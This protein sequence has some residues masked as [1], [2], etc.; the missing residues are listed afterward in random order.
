GPLR[1]QKIPQKAGFCGTWVKKMEQV[2]ITG[3]SMIRGVSGRGKHGKSHEESYINSMTSCYIMAVCPEVQAEALI[4]AVT[5]L[6][7]R[8]GGICVVSDVQKV[9]FK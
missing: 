5:P 6:L 8:F 1:P 4:V 9:D 2:G 3:Y 7:K